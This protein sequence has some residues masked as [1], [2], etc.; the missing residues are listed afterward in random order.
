MTKTWFRLLYTTSV[1]RNTRN[2][3]ETET[4]ENHGENDQNQT[5]NKRMKYSV[6]IDETNSSELKLRL[7]INSLNFYKDWIPGSQ[8]RDDTS[9]KQ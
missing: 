8:T 9:S 3:T 2:R 4:N 5:E 7:H 6:L 1:T